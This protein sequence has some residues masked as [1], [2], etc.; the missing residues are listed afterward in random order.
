M[1]KTFPQI[2]WGTDLK[3][4]IRRR[5][6]ALKV[7]RSKVGSITVEIWNHPKRLFQG[8][9]LP[10]QKRLPEGQP[11]ASPGLYVRAV[12]TEATV[13][14]RIRH[15]TAWLQFSKPHLNE[16]ENMKG[17]F[18]GL[19][20]QETMSLTWIPI[21]VSNGSQILP[22]AIPAGTHGASTFFSHLLGMLLS[23]RYWKTESFLY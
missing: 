13:L 23:S 12:R 14:L 5:K 22:I 16:S 20:R 19:M 6:K 2:D 18:S 8:L 17:R 7:P 9:K 10:K 15:M 21:A 3:R 4:R 1:Q 11:S